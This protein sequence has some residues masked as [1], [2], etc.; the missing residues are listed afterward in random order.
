MPALRHLIRDLSGR[1]LISTLEWSDEE[2][3]V[4]LGLA[5][6]FKEIAQYYGTEAIPK[7]LAGKVFF[8]LFFA[9]STRTRAAFEAGMYYLG[10]H[11]AYI[12]ATTTRLAY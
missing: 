11:A 9:P 5:R 2:I 4:A 6:E 12:D 1:D 3:N 8:M 7:I 10:G